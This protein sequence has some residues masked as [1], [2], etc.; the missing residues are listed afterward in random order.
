MVMET[1]DK[2]VLLL[3][4]ADGLVY[5]SSKD[6]LEESIQ[7]LNEKINNMY[8]KTGATHSCF[9]ISQGRYFRHNIDPNYK[10][11]R[12]NIKTSLKWL[13]TLKM[14]LKEAY[15]AQSMTNCE[16]DDLVAYW[17]NSDLIYGK[18][19]INLEEKFITRKNR[20]FNQEEEYLEIILCSP[21][22][23]LLQSIEGKH[24]N[25]TYKDENNKGWWVITTKE[26]AEKFKWIQMLMGDTTDSIPSLS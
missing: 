5:H 4:D 21:D 14:Y 7:V 3:V 9:F 13:Q 10:K 24:F 23:D 6:T 1:I 17:Y 19:Y 8:E 26:E 18:I 20:A 16:A 22:K 12:N 15:N 11:L 25:Y 2:P